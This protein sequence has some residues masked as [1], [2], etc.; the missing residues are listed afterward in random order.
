M[1]VDPAALGILDA[2][3]AL[4]ADPQVADHVAA[5]LGALD[6]QQRD[7]L[8]P[9]LQRF[10]AAVQTLTRLLDD[11]V[12]RDAASAPP[13]QPGPAQPPWFE[14]LAR[15]IAT[16]DAERVV[17]LKASAAP[18]IAPGIAAWLD[19]TS[20]TRD[21]ELLHLWA[22]LRAAP[23][24]PPTPADG[25]SPEHEAPL[26]A[27]AHEARLYAASGLRWLAD[28]AT[29][30]VER[31]GPRTLWA[32][33]ARAVHDLDRDELDDAE[34]SYQHAAM[35]WPASPE[36]YAGLA[37]IAE[38][39]G[40]WTDAY[41]YYEHLASLCV[42]AP[43]PLDRLRAALFWV[44][45]TGRSSADATGGL[46][47][48]ANH[49]QLRA[50][51][52]AVRQRALEL[53]IAGDC[54]I[55]APWLLDARVALAELLERDADPVAGRAFA[56]VASSYLAAR[57]YD[58]AVQFSRRAIA[59]GKTDAAAYWTL[60]DDLRLCDLSEPGRVDE[61]IA[62]WQ[63]GFALQRPSY[64]TWWALLA[65]A[66]LGDVYRGP[67]RAEQLAAALFFGEWAAAMVGDSAVCWSYLARFNRTL[68]G[69]ATALA[70]VERAVALAP[71]SALVR[72]EHAAAL[73]SVGRSREALDVLESRAATATGEPDLR[74]LRSV[75][76]YVLAN[77]GDNR[78]ALA[79]LQ[80]GGEP[81]VAPIMAQV[82]RRLGDREAADRLCRELWDD[83]TRS[84]VVRA[85]VSIYLG[86]ASAGEQLLDQAPLDPTDDPHDA[87]SAR[88]W[89]RAAQR[90]WNGAE[91][92]V[93]AAVAALRV[94]RQAVMLSAELR[95]TVAWL[96]GS[97]PE[98]AR[99]GAAWQRW[100]DDRARTRELGPAVIA[101]ERAR[102]A[103]LLSATH[104][105][106]FPALTALREASVPDA[107]TAAAAQL[108]AITP[109]LAEA[110]IA[111]VAGAWSARGD[112]LLAADAG[113]AAYELYARAAVLADSAAL[114]MR[115]AWRAAVA[116]PAMAARAT[117]H[118]EQA[119][120]AEL[121]PAI[122][123]L[124]DQLSSRQVWLAIAALVRAGRDTGNAAWAEL[125]AR[126]RA[127][128]PRTLD[129]GGALR[130]P[131]PVVLQATGAAAGAISTLWSAAQAELAAL[132][133]FELPP[134]EV[135]HAAA[136]APHVLIDGLAI[137]P[138]G[139]RGGAADDHDAIPALLRAAG[140]V[141]RD[142][143]ARW[144]DVDRADR[145]IAS[146][147]RGDPVLGPDAAPWHGSAAE[148]PVLLAVLQAA[149][150]ERI[151]SRAVGDAIVRGGAA[152][153]PS[154]Y[155]TIRRAR[156]ASRDW[157]RDRVVE[158]RT[159]VALAGAV[160][161]ELVAEL[162]DDELR[163]GVVVLGPDRR[164]LVEAIW[165]AAPD[166]DAQVLVARD[167]RARFAVA[168]I[169]AARPGFVPVVSVEEQLV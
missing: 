116:G 96:G 66:M 75:Q 85:S 115:R 110:V 126:V 33:L 40:F 59:A 137:A 124:I 121:G 72:D 70:L 63:S 129:V 12:G 92:H 29:A 54:P 94:P 61:A 81:W 73:A 118:A 112:A 113:D 159:A 79:V 52:R 68:N 128:A 103:L 87:A 31:L 17:A 132:V 127:S 51:D 60:A 164:A 69:D 167:P 141:E 146:W 62:V 32:A 136:V 130:P 35:R 71:A 57:D 9:Q 65:R 139:P 19:E 165:A 149:A 78:A 151:P 95:D 58:K 7:E 50:S 158:G 56:D 64:A 22:E 131:A 168:L 100:I 155:A 166:R 125:A 47:A 134:A 11:S 119:V 67:D 102:A 43:A 98:A 77:L 104:H 154:V 143:L 101:E 117:R 91:R 14:Q 26:I 160:E 144:I 88:A 36:S 53:A 83:T 5:W 163:R 44:R 120:A 42:H 162:D 39:R 13:G 109:G 99:R 34:S 105:A 6:R 23:G 15:G 150:R 80:R 8:R 108:R 93:R 1:T 24:W 89:L 114:R 135:R 41:S 38:V 49:P 55:G 133:G 21:G 28:D 147:G 97:D 106:G 140:A 148:L 4:G 16:G 74:W 48:L 2:I 20:P 157:L 152:A 84:A 25:A 30:R 18:G 161:A 145:A 122:G 45:S 111:S 82:M 10:A 27:Y 46:L 169:A 90:D 123:G 153:A 156:A 86:L 76:G 138:G 107:V 3:K 37:A 142:Q